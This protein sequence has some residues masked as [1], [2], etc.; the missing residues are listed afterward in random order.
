[1]KGLQKHTLVWAVE[2]FG[3]AAVDPRERAARLVEEAIEVAQALGLEPDVIK[4]ISD[5]VYSRPLGELEQEIGGVGITA[6][7]LDESAGIDFEAA[8]LKEWA[9]I[10]SKSRA[11]W[12]KKHDEK[13]EA[14]TA[15]P[16]RGR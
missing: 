8:T 6:L 3:S 2:S 14:G 4:T 5:R 16:S 7:N 10:Q 1:M 9:R 11:H 12:Q 15:F 13:V